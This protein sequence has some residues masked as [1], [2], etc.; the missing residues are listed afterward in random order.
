[1]HGHK[2]H[3]NYKD[4]VVAA[5]EATFAYHI[6]VY[7]LSFKASDCTSNLRS[8]FSESKFGI[9]RTN[10][11]ATVVNVI[12]PMCNEELHIQL[13]NSDIVLQSIL[14][15][16]TDIK[17]VPAIVHYFLPHAGMKVNKHNFKS[18][19][20]KTSEILTLCLLS[21]TKNMTLQSSSSTQRI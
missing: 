20:G 2:N 16:K 19:L 10:F 1:M 15:K 18:V 9:A 12:S 17:V 8:R 7:S 13:N 3:V 11:K 14:L 21:V 4:L 5:K 6:A